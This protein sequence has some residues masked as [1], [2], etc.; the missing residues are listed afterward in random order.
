MMAI[1]MQGSWTV[2]VKSKSAAFPQRFIIAGADSGNGT[3]VGAVTT[4]PV[5]VSGPNWR[6]K[7]RMIRAA[8]RQLGG[9][10]Q[11]PDYLRRTIPVR[12]REQRLGWRRRLQRSNP[13]VLHC[14]HANRFHRLRECDV[15]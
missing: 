6:I 12:Y 5:P 4:T 7:F 15:L 9:S 8:G 14:G 3:Y 10:D 2:S 11:V 1:P 13:H